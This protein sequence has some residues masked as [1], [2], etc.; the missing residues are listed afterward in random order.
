MSRSYPDRPIVGVGAVVFRGNEVLLIRRGKPPR[1]GDWS[2]PGGMQEIGETVFEAA[3]REVQEETG[4]TISDIA[5]IDVVD[6]ITLDDDAGVQFHYTL[7]AVVA[8]WRS[9]EPAG[10]TD[11][12]HAEFVSLDEASKMVLWR[13]THRIIAKAREMRGL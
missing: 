7:N 6:S 5:L 8:K 2:L 11:A 13:E 10:G 12:M 9:G 4:V 1:M 3:A